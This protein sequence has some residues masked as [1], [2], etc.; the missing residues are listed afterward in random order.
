MFLPLLS[1]PL[2]CFD[3]NRPSIPLRHRF[4]LIWE[5]NEALCAEID[6]PKR[7]RALLALSSAEWPHCSRLQEATD[8]T[9]HAFNFSQCDPLPHKID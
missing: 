6:A 1:E 7:E 4:L 5:S 9:L 8:V 3:R 2:R